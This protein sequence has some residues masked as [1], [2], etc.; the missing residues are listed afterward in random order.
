MGPRR[1]DDRSSARS[2]WRARRSRSSCATW[3]K[4]ARSN[5]CCVRR[6][7][8]SP[9]RAP[10][11]A[12]GALVDYDCILIMPTSRR[13][14][15]R[16]RCRRRSTPAAA[17]DGDAATSSTTT[18]IRRRRSCRREP[19]RQGP[20][21]AATTGQPPMQ[22]DAAAAQPQQTL[23][24]PG[25]LPHGADRAGQSVPNPQQPIRAARRLA[26]T[27]PAAPGGVQNPGG[28]GASRRSR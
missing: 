21:H 26:R 15:R 3:P 19:C 14:P 24:R 4:D 2:G 23:P 9:S 10:A 12:A 27:G 5:R 28:A 20:Q 16:T 13:P 7:A 25:M 17:A 18:W 11:T 1:P 6:A 22:P 8:T